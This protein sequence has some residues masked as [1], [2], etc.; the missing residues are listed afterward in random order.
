MADKGFDI[1]VLPREPKVQLIIPPFLREI[2]PQDVQKT[3][4][5]ASLEYMLNGLMD[6]GVREYQFLIQVFHYL[7]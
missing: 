2:F 6:L 5:N 7:L 4:T 3:K 1:N